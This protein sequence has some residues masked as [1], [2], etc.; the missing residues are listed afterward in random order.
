LLYG[1]NSQ[2]W[3]NKEPVTNA[4]KPDK[5]SSYNQYIALRAHG[6]KN[7]LDLALDLLSQTTVH[8]QKILIM[9]QR[10]TKAKLKYQT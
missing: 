4:Q 6:M 5:T 8:S 7:G 1:L 3:E 10:L 9:L 2:G